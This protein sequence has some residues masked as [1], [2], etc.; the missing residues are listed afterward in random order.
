MLTNTGRAL[1]TVALSTTVQFAKALFQCID[2]TYNQ[3]T[4]S[5]YSKTKAWSLITRLIVRIFQDIFAPWKGKQNFMKAAEPIQ[6]AVT[7]Y[8]SMLKSLEITCQC[9]E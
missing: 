1:V 2:T 6:V 4:R 8:Y 7:I 9:K 3:L 5:K